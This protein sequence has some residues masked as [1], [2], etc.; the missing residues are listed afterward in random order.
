M[1]III[2]GSRTIYSTALVRLAIRE[3]GFEITEIVSG[4]ARGIDQ[5]AI[6]VATIDGIPLKTFPAD[7]DKFGKAAGNLR[8]G[9]MGDYGGGLIAIWDGESR[10]TGNM[11]AHM[12][13]RSKPSYIVR[14]VPE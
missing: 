1:K 6:D 10:G 7:W 13:A 11:I 2:A 5:A 9:E 12:R 3:S 4:M 14:T 8:N